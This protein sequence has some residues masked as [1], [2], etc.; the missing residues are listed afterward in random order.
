MAESLRDAC[1]LPGQF[2]SGAN[3]ERARNELLSIGGIL[4]GGSCAEI[5]LFQEM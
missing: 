1:E 3:Y 4:I 5:R 2:V